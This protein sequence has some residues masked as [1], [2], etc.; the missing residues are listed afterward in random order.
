M[1]LPYK[2]Y[3]SFVGEQT[4]KF[5]RG[6]HKYSLS[7]YIKVNKHGVHKI[8]KSKIEHIYDKKNIFLKICFYM[9]ILDVL[10]PLVFSMELI[11]CP[12]TVWWTTTPPAV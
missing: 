10:K 12:I 11:T 7:L 3:H 6:L 5:I 9:F 4:Y 8:N 1:K 2:L